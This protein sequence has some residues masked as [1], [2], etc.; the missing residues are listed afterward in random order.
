MRERVVPYPTKLAF[1]I[2][3]FI[4]VPRTFYA[5]Y[6]NNALSADDE[7]VLVHERVHLRREQEAGL[8]RFGYKYLTQPQFRL[9]EEL[10]AIKEE[11]KFRKSKGITY[12]IERKARHFAGAEYRYLLP[13]EE[14]KRV[15]TDLWQTGI[16]KP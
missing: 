16:L 9:T 4:F 13:Y 12:D 2:R 5:R 7:A 14:A 11:M 8:L 15:L 1:A 10:I 3:P 6:R